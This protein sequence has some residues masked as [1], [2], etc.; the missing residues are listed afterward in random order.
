MRANGK[1]SA[2]FIEKKNADHI[3]RRTATEEHERAQLLAR[4]VRFDVFG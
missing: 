4:H 3:K 2:L 1:S